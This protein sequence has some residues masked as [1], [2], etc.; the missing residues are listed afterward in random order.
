LCQAFSPDGLRWTH[1]S[2]EEPAQLG[3][4]I[5]YDKGDWCD[6]YETA[7][8]LKRDGSYLLYYVGYN[9]R[10]GGFFNSFPV[11]LGLMTSSDGVHFD[12]LPGPVLTNTRR[13]WDAD[14]IASP[15]IVEHQGSL[16]M[17]YT[18]HCWKDCA[19]TP[20]MRVLG[21]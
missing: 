12:R 6:T 18:G 15:S 16:Y 10:G 17:V 14:G 20:G 4:V 9:D 8:A 5:R 3:R 7:F 13:G 1:A 21:A 19:D 11:Q 2:T